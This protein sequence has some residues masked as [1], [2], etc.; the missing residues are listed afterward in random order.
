MFL[1]PI[2]LM[3]V[4]LTLATI[5]APLVVAQKERESLRLFADPG[6]KDCL[7][8]AVSREKLL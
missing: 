1:R 8:L 3:L 5:A 2:T 4:L 7:R 6:M